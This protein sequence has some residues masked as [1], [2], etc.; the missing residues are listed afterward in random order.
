MSPIRVSVIVSTYSHPKW[1]LK[2]L[3]GFAQQSPNA[4]ELIVADHGIEPD[5]KSIAERFRRHSGMLIVHVEHESKG[6]KKCTT[7][8]NAIRAAKSDYLIFTDAGCIPRHDFV[9]THLALREPG[10]FLSGGYV[11]L[12][13]SVS[14]VICGVDIEQGRHADPAWLRA[15][16]FRAGRQALKLLPDGLLARALDMF[17]PIRAGWNGHNSSGWKADLVNVNGFDERMEGGGEDRELGRR[18]ENAG[19]YG[20]RIRFR[21]SVVHLESERLSVDSGA[22]AVQYSVN[23]GTLVRRRREK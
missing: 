2:C 8:N 4:F 5:T 10:R 23:W 6:S 15:R 16:G 3:I 12:P 14:N 22:R 19:I 18:L 17:S 1:L 11:R 7:L 9:G 20:K 21:A 13:T